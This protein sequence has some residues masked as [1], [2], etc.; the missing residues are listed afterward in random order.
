MLVRPGG[1]LVYSTCSVEIEENEAVV[2]AFLA[3]QRDF[4]RTELKHPVELLTL[5][6]D[7][8]T[9]PH[10]QGVDGFFVAALEPKP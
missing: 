4:A 8:R 1:R 6:G 2:D 7:I 9:W 3:T 10:H 5:A